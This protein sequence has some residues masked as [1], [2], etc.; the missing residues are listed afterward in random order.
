MRPLRLTLSG[1]RSYPGTC[2]IDF[3]GKRLL[4]ILGDTGAGKSTLLEAIIFAL[5]GRCSWA[6]DS[7]ELIGKG[8]PSMSVAFEF[9][10]D[11]RSWSVRR[12]LFAKRSKR[13]K[14]VLEPLDGGSPLER[15]DSKRDVNEAVSQI[16]GL[17]CDGFV[18]TVLLRQ[19]R[20][21]AL[22]KA[23]PAHR[24]NILRHIFGIHELERV[25]KH[26]LARMERLKASATDAT[27][28][29]AR[30]L[31]DPAAAAAKAAVDVERTRGTAARRRERLDLLRQAQ[32]E[33][34]ESQQR[35]AEL[36][37]AAR[38]LR[39]RATADAGAVMAVLAQAKQALDAEAAAQEATGYE[40]R[41]RM[42]AAQAA[43]DTAAEAGHTVRSLASARTV[44]SRLPER[45]SELDTRAQRLE[46]ERL[47]HGAQEQEDAQTRQDLQEREQ[48]RTALAEAAEQAKQ[49]VSQARTDTDQ[50]HEAVRAALQEAAA[51]AAHL[52]TQRTTLES[53]DEQRARSTRLEE[54]LGGLHE[55]CNVAQDA[56]AALQR[57][58]A[59]HTAGSTLEPGDACPVCTQPLPGGF[60]PPLPS[61][62]KAL[63]RA[64]RE[65]RKHTQAVTK[66]V[67]AAAHA[68]AELGAAEAKADEHGR[69]YLG[70]RE[71]I[72]AVLLQLQESA[73]AI[74]PTC[75]PAAATA[76]DALIQ[77][78][79]DQAHALSEG[80]PRTRAQLTRAVAKLV[81]P[82]RDAEADTLAAHASAQA[83]LAAAQAENDAARAE[84][85]R[86]RARLQRE[87]KRLDKAQ[88]QY[89][90]DLLTLA[91]EIAE[92]PVPLRPGDPSQEKLPTASAIA[93]AKGAVE[94]LL[95]QLEQ[96]QHDCDEARQ[97]LA[98]HAED[99]QAL[100]ERRQLTVQAPTRALITRLERWADAAA[101][102]QAVL[103][104]QAP[105][106]LPP[107]V[108]GT[109][110]PG[111][112]AYAAALTALSQ[113]LAEGLKQASRQAAVQIRAFE[114]E[115][116]AQAGAAADGTDPD[117]GFPLPVKGGLLAP[118]VLDPLS[119]KAS[120]AE[121]AHDKAKTDLSTAQ[122][123]IPYAQTLDTA[124]QEAKRQIAVWQSVCD[125]LTD[126]H[127][128]SYLTERRTRALLG[129]GSR[130]LKQL[131]G[132]VYAFTEDFRIVDLA[133]NL[134]R[135][136]ETLSGGE[137]FQTSLALALALVELHSRS[138]S[139]LE[140][141]FLDEG[142]ASLDADRLE[143]ALAV[144]R[145][146]VMTGDKTIAVISH[147]YSVAEAVDD[148]LW[149][150]K[151]A[152]GSTASWL[153]AKER[154]DFISDGIQRLQEQA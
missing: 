135:S 150:S 2:T 25:R 97:A 60:T 114:K 129:H 17:D 36:D 42:E 131:S 151:D 154:K 19:G 31:P 90:S 10:I 127:F 93:C 53:V 88:Q 89:E 76:L 64:K 21:D 79:T 15:F 96:T 122:S 141:L 16:I 145:N 57:R 103:D 66:A 91:K 34:A 104:D 73:V 116:T 130:I 45:V 30:L 83:Q 14:A 58:E 153:T 147:L 136:P 143:D 44:L 124:L 9:S 142:F 8:H 55:A 33:A 101:D 20:F 120:K 115:L 18:S 107:A 22:L 146:S 108:D 140:S 138:H 12:T 132:G 109:D 69:G 46:Q 78:V 105:A 54:Q 59:A 71:R 56:L 77:Q 126:A 82:L 24:A 94:Q 37:R 80:V 39:E 29:R 32:H 102:A 128:L 61:D 111:V 148:V 11:G 26:T 110:L 99:R 87:R 62:G 6:A 75:S 125:Q 133:T 98:A 49:A 65:V 72:E 40:L 50:V 74:R 139:T 119:R 1:V 3:T 92:L 63:D 118:A 52:Q 112:E 51:A 4:G 84:L 134:T 86:Q 68:A 100:Q 137:T 121:V 70:T 38:L 23:A 41:L 113:R 48:G 81:Q 67:S 35:K 123:Q 7:H 85:K 144:L 28:A 5:Y 43:L 13:P 95:P 117:P 149:V 152:R 47:L 27:W 106:E